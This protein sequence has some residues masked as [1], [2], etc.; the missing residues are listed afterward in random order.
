MASDNKRKT[1]GKTGMAILLELLPRPSDL[2]SKL[3]LLS[4]RGD[5][6][7]PLPKVIKETVP[8]QGQG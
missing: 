7:T 2:S 6:D 8:R 1:N 3:Q 5:K 4:G